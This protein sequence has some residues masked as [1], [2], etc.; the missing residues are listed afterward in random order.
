MC[1][2]LWVLECREHPVKEFSMGVLGRKVWSTVV[3]KMVELGGGWYRASMPFFVLFFWLGEKQVPG[4]NGSSHG[5][6]SSSTPVTPIL[7]EPVLSPSPQSSN[8]VRLQICGAPENSNAID[9]IENGLLRNVRPWLNAYHLGQGKRCGCV[10][11]AK[12]PPL[13][14]L[15]KRDGLHSMILLQFGCRRNRAGF[16]RVVLSIA[17]YAGQVWVGYSYIGLFSL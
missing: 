17:D 7:A 11:L 2:R 12:I 9:L 16:S 4:W 15:W 5:H 8:E 3:H 1:L 13:K 14:R 6:C 10:V